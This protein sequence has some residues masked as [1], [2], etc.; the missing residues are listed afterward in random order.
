MITLAF[1]VASFALFRKQNRYL[2]ALGLLCSMLAAFASMY[3]FAPHLIVDTIPVG[4]S[5]ILV[6]WVVVV[7]IFW[8]VEYVTGE[9]Q[10]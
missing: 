2:F 5:M 4:L 3:E 9:K 8:F 7:G 10:W 6:A 1:V